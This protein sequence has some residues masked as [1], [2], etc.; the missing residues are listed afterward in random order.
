LKHGVKRLS[1]R[2]EPSHESHAEKRRGNCFRKASNLTERVNQAFP[3]EAQ[4][5]IRD[6][7]IGIAKVIAQTS[8]EDEL[9]NPDQ[10][11]AIVGLSLL[12]GPHI[13]LDE[14]LREA[15]EEND[16]PLSV[17]T[18]ILRTARIAE[19]SAFGQIADDRIKVIKKI[20]QLKDDPATLEAA[21]QSLISEAPWLLNPQWS[22]ITAN[23]SFSTL[24]DEF[25]KFYKLETGNDLA[26]EPFESNTKRAD[27]VLSNQDNI[28]HI[29]EIKRPHH[30]LENDELDRLN[31]YMDL[32]EK[33]LRQPGNSKFKDLF[34]K[35]HVTLVCD[36][37]ALQGVHRTAFDGLKTEKRLTHINWKTFLLRTRKMHEAFLNE[38]ERQRKN[39]A[40]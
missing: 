8:R 20:E 3:N 37:L 10:V 21:F 16:D 2:L 7:T 4:K 13:T 34:P 12:L 5:D 30:A 27:F 23:Q 36:K 19:L 28:L 9:Q 33:F 22:P 35:F 11:E 32:M 31:R 38:A 39:V 26:L 40:K 25:Q 1:N 24:K 17:I 29:I 18:T 6:K 15:A 14:K